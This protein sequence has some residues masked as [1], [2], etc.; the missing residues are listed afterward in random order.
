MEP[1]MCQFRSARDTSEKLPCATVE[2]VDPNISNKSHVLHTRSPL[3]QCAVLQTDCSSFGNSRPAIP[4][5]A[6]ALHKTQQRLSSSHLDTM[7]DTPCPESSSRQDHYNNVLGLVHPIQAPI[8]LNF[9]TLVPGPSVTATP[10]H[11]QTNFDETL[12][13]SF[14]PHSTITTSSSQ[15]Y[16]NRDS[17]GSLMQDILF[18]N[19]HLPEFGRQFHSRFDSVPQIAPMPETLIWPGFSSADATFPDISTP[20]S[21]ASTPNL[22]FDFG[23]VDHWSAAWDITVPSLTW[24]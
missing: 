1:S 7:L 24:S 15:P 21:L 14:D 22:D 4:V 11:Y 3:L 20:S 8:E 6:P 10:Y 13:P 5:S 17:F 19:D 16:N 12:T 23:C 18:T 9:D 2:R